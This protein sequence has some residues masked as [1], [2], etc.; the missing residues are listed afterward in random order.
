[1][2][3]WRSRVPSRMFQTRQSGGIHVVGQQE[4]KAQD[5]RQTAW[6]SVLFRPRLNSSVGKGG[7]NSRESSRL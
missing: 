5:K 6:G 3:R 7:G 4:A 1:M 2:C